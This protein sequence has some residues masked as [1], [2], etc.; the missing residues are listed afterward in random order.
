MSET[1]TILY[2]GEPVSLPR[3]VADFLEQDRKREQAQTRQD[4]RH[5]SRSE[6]ETVPSSRES[7]SRPAE[8][9]TL[10]NLHLE[11]LRNAI[12]ELDQ[13]DQDLLNFRHGKELT[14]EEIGAV[15]GISKMVVSK[16]LRKLHEKLKSSV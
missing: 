14:M 5:L 8:D 2:C 3:E 15:Y 11:N 1:V 13:R 9:D 7:V 6:F 12:E 4:T 16:R 10:R